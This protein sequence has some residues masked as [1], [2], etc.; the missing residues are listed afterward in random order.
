M[1]AEV[2]DKPRGSSDYVIIWMANH[3]VNDGKK[4]VQAVVVFRYKSDF[5]CICLR[6]RAAE[7]AKRRVW[8]GFIE[9]HQQ[10]YLPTQIKAPEK[11]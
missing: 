11:E 1:S 5:E 6:V 9:T 8:T 2:R 10:I 4:M 3:H 7:P